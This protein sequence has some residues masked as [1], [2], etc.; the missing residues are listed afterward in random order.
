[1]TVPLVA[2]TTRTVIAPGL[3]EPSKHRMRSFMTPTGTERLVVWLSS[4]QTPG[5]SNG[6]HLSQEAVDS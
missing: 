3:Q 1:M 4:G 5:M 6:M 2:P